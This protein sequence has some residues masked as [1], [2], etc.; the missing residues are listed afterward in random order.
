M[1]LNGNLNG[2]GDFFSK[3]LD[4]VPDVIEKVTTR[5]ERKTAQKAAIET[6]RPITDF[7]FDAQQSAGPIPSESALQQ[8]I[9]PGY[10]PPVSTNTLLL[11]AAGGLAYL[12]LSRRGRRG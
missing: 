4:K 8:Y 1:N 6:G 12:L 9:P 10:A 11:M 3:I 7:S 5:N 2:F